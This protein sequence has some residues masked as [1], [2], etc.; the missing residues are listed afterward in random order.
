[1]YVI[2]LAL[3]IVT[4]ILMRSTTQKGDI[5]P[6]IMELPAYHM[7]SGKG[8]AVHLWDKIK[9]YLQKV[10]TVILAST[11]VIW[12]LSNF[13]WNWKMVEIDQSILAS[14]GKFVQPLF[15]PLGF[16]SQLGGLGWVFAV[17]AIMGLIAKENVL[18]AFLTMAGVIFGMM[19]AGTLVNPEVL[20]PEIVA[21]IEALLASGEFG[22]EGYEVVAMIAA[23][24]ISWEALVAFIVFNMSTIPCFA[25]VATARGELGKGRFVGTLLFW[26]ATS[27]VA[28]AITYTVLSWWW[29]SLVWLA[30]AFVAVLLIV[31][32]NKKKAQNV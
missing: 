23:T 32:W 9:H 13:G 19:Q 11:V 21:E 22:E 10:F 17:A 12:F 16:G 7:P 25:A 14:L 24:G 30:V 4:I 15:T 28:S 26:M 6:F 29:T 20:R 27:Y 2:G 3:A 8:L 5:A 31:I 1:M 18:A